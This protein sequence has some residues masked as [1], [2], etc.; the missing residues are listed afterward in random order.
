M[1]PNSK[2]EIHLYVPYKHN[3]KVILYNHFDSFVHGTKF[4]LGTYMWNFALMVSC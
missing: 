1:A 2:H 3:L 4:V